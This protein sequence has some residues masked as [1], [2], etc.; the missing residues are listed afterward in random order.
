[1]GR[2]TPRN[3]HH[4]SSL[5]GAIELGEYD[6]GHARGF[7]ELARLLQ[8]VL[9]GG[10]VE[11]QQH[12]VW[13]LGNHLLGGA[14]HLLQLGHQ[15]FLGLQAAGGVDDHVIGFAGARRAHGV[16]KHRAGVAAR[17]LPH[18][19]RSCALAPDLESPIA[20]ARKVSAA[21]SITLR[22]SLLN[23][24]DGTIQKLYINGNLVG[25]QAVTG[26][27]AASS[28]ALYIGSSQSNP[29]R[30][31]AGCLDEVR[32]WNVARTQAQIQASMNC[33]ISCTN[34]GL[35]AYYQFNQGIAGGTNNGL[36][37]ATDCSGNS[38]TGILTNFA[39]NG[40]TSNWV[41]P[42]GVTSGSSCLS[43]DPT[44]GTA[45]SPVICLGNSTT[46]GISGGSLA[47]GANWYWYSI[48]CGSSL[49]ASGAG[50]VV[51]P[52]INTTYWVEA[53]YR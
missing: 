16:E 51:S 35:A 22:C 7:G 20:A 29:T 27:I 52:T 14:G 28:S 9:P 42:G 47:D 8:T 21:Q 11:H 5:G 26:T 25:S 32:I 45:N 38:N 31:F 36:D 3:G 17:V 46:L 10:R 23:T 44:S 43:T 1:M 48:S 19:R 18:H 40:A 12:L 6:A 39:L 2:S 4:D 37:S 50:P 30:L 53:G 41:A 49:F 34:C 15:V 13:R 24:Y 33:E